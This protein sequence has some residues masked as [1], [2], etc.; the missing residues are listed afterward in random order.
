MV[1]RLLAIVANTAV[2]AF[3]KTVY[4]TTVAS[5]LCVVFYIGNELVALAAS[6]GV[7]RFDR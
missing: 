7:S 6:K 4:S 1:D 5:V 2:V 3:A